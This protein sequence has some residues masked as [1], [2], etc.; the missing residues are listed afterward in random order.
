M[1]ATIERFYKELQD[2]FNKTIEEMIASFVLSNLSAR[3]LNDWDN[4]IEWCD[5]A[6]MEIDVKDEEDKTCEDCVKTAAINI[7]LA[8]MYRLDE[9]AS[10]EE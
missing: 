7:I 1:T 5:T 9:S 10:N 2:K 4:I 8:I 6:L 3:L